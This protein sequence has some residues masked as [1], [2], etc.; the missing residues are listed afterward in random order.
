[1]KSAC[2][3]TSILLAIVV[4]SY[5]AH[6]SR[7]LIRGD[8]GPETQPQVR[9]GVGGPSDPE[10][11]KA[12]GLG[13]TPAEVE[14]GYSLSMDGV[15]VEPDRASLGS[16]TTGSAVASDPSGLLKAASEEPVRFEIR[17]SC[18]DVE[19]AYLL[20]GL[21]G[22]QPPDK[23]LWPKGTEEL[24]GLPYCRMSR[25][26][27]DFSIILTVPEGRTLDFCFHILSPSKGL[28]IWD[29]N[30]P[31]KRDYHSVASANGVALVFGRDL[32]QHKETA[33]E[34]IPL[35]FLSPVI[36]VAV[37]FVIVLAATPVLKR[38][39]RNRPSI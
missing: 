32:R 29:V 17:Y 7:T 34:A 1:M 12:R 35:R 5:P 31:P 2:P 25:P 15:A 27:D 39:T 19:S 14:R 38:R 3:A 13:G 10:K 37:A 6:G 4:F 22:W 28:D 8:S 23:A 21:D 9:F 11:G 24:N 20:W 16:L 30:V 36:F 26:G 18:P 33:P